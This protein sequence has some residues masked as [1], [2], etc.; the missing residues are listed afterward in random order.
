MNYFDLNHKK[1]Y[2]KYIKYLDKTKENSKKRNCEFYNQIF[3]N[4]RII[5]PKDDEKFV[6][7]I[8]KK[9]NELRVLFEDNGIDK[10]DEK[11]LVLYAKTFY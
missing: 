4:F 1:D 9:F 10:I 2:E 6:Q 11:T 5:Y 3:N 8:E 7:E